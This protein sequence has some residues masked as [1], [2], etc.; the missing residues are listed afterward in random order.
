MGLHSIVIG[1]DTMTNIP[2]WSPWRIGHL[3]L[4]FSSPGFTLN[5]DLR[6]E[7]GRQLDH[8]YSDCDTLAGLEVILSLSVFYGLYRR[9]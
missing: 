6:G 5:G 4:P 8:H 2:S 7:V 9:V 3:W 1:L